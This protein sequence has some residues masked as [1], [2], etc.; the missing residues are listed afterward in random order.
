MVWLRS[1][2]LRT[3]AAICVSKATCGR[4]RLGVVRDPC[5]EQR[6]DLVAH[7]RDLEAIE[8]PAQGRRVVG[9]LDRDDRPSVPASASAK[10]RALA[11]PRVVEEEPDADSG[12]GR[13]PRLERR[14]P[15]A[16]VDLDPRRVGDR[17]GQ[18]G[19]QVAGLD[20]GRSGG[21]SA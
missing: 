5:H 4:R 14:D 18:R 1:E 3:Y 21:W 2:A 19:R 17:G 7:D 9:A 16:G 6:L 12:L 10:G 8:Q 11:R 15:V 13:Q 20:R